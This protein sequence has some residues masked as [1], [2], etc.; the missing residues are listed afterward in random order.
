MT[1]ILVQAEM[2]DDLKIDLLESTKNFKG[3][4]LDQIANAAIVASVNAGWNL[5]GTEIWCDG[6]LCSRQSRFVVDEKNY[7]SIYEANMEG[8]IVP[9]DNGKI[10]KI[11]V[12]MFRPFL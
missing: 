4:V 8:A 9:N 1:E 3:G 5:T 12:K 2:R 7:I 6:V 10:R 11:K